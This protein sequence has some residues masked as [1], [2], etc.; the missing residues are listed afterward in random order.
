MWEQ[1]SPSSQTIEKIFIDL[2][3]YLFVTLPTLTPM[4]LPSGLTAA[5][6]EPSWSIFN[7]CTW[8]DLLSCKST[9]KGKKVKKNITLRAFRYMSPTR[10]ES[11]F[12]PRDLTKVFLSKSNTGCPRKCTNRMEPW[13]Y[14][15]QAQSPAVGTTWTW[16][17]FFGLLWSFLAKTK[18]DQAPPSHVH[19]KI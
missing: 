17:V 18:Q 10:N 6:L 14:G 7:Q 3:T 11:M 1:N 2:I 19:G 9:G 12:T 4:I 13:C 15:A 8:E 5:M 16:N